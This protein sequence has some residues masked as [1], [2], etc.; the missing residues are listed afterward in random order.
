MEMELKMSKNK[1]TKTLIK[2]PKKTI[3]KVLRGLSTSKNIICRMYAAQNPNLPKDCF[4][5][6]ANDEDDEVRSELAKNPNFPKKI[7]DSYLEQ[8]N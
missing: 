1:R 3:K 5:K 6:L 8:N 7:L 4:K 2:K